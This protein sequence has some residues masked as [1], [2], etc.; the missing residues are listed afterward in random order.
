MPDCLFT[1]PFFKQPG[2][3]AGPYLPIKITNPKTGKSIEWYCLIDTGADSCLFS[4]DIATML[5]H[6]LKGQGVKSCVSIGFEG[7]PVT[8][9]RHTFSI[10]LVHP[11]KPQTVVWTGKNTLFDCIHHNNCPQLLGVADFL[12]F[13]LITI[14][15]RKKHT[16]LQ[17]KTS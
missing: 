13:F 12:K 3:P 4:G 5:G 16:I 9:Y 7:T 11:T 17:F 14:D 1:Y 10:A 8:T 15:Y 2:R 6:S